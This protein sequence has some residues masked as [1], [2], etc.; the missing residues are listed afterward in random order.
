[1][2]TPLSIVPPHPFRGGENSVFGKRWFCLRATR[3]FRHFRRSRGLKSTTPSLSGPPKRRSAKEFDH[4][5]SERDSFGHFLVTSSD[6]SVTIFVTFLPISFCRTPFAAGR[7][8]FLWVESRYLHPARCPPPQNS[9]P[10]NFGG[11]PDLI[12]SRFRSDFDLLLIRFASQPA[13]NQIKSGSKSDRGLG[14]FARVAA[15]GW[16]WTWLD[17][18]FLWVER[19]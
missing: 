10:C 13:R 16:A 2:V 3:H 15:L 8:L 5:F 18:M 11:E 7:P 6:A 1:M 19:K 17:Q 14:W 4:F 12:L 9:R